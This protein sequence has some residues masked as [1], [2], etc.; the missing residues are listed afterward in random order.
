MH[1]RSLNIPDVEHQ[2]NYTKQISSRASRCQGACIAAIKPEYLLELK[3]YK[4]WLK[5]EKRNLAK[6]S[7]EEKAEQEL[8]DDILF[9]V[10]SKRSWMDLLMQILKVRLLPNSH[11]A[12]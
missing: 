2:I 8:Q 1:P 6:M 4:H 12:N 5:M 10:L 11:H 7:V 9:E 3:D